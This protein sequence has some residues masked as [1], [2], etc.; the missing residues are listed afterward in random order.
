MLVTDGHGGMVVE[1]T[2]GAPPVY[3]ERAFAAPPANKPRFDDGKGNAVDKNGLPLSDF[4]KAD[5][6]GEAWAVDE[7][8][9]LRGDSGAHAAYVTRF[10]FGFGVCRCGA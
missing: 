9:T 4:A 1:H 3:L 5:E 8:L 7:Q 6:Q 2:F 10:G